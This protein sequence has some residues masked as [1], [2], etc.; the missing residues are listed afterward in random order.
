MYRQFVTE[1]EDFMNMIV[2]QRR[3]AKHSLFCK[4]HKTAFHGQNNIFS[5]NFLTMHNIM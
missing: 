3:N 1:M 2:S 4:N 5:H